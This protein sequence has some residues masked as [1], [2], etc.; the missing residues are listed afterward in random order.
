MTASALPA[1]RAASSDGAPGGPPAGP[2][3]P[4]VITG[5]IAA[6]AAAGT[7]LVLITLLALAGWIAAPHAGVGLPGVLRTAADLWLVGHH[8]GFALHGAGQIGAGRIGM[9]P[10]G[11]VLLP[12]ALLWVAGRWVVRKGEVTRLA[13]VGY[14]ALALAVPYA[15]VAGALALAGQSS[16]AAPSLSQAVLAGFLLALVAGGLG[17]ARALAPWRHLIHLLPPRTRSLFLG[18]LG[19]L[20]VLT[21]AGAILAGASLAASMDGFRA[22]NA[23]LAPGAV[24]AALLLLIQIAYIPNAIVWSICYTLG[25]GFAFGAGTVVAPTGSALGS[26]P[27]LP[28]L[29]ALPSG[30]HSAVP[31]W[32]SV[33]MLSVPYLAGVFGGLLTARAAPTPAI[34]LA[35]LW[36]FAC[37]V[38]TGCAMGL[39]AAFAGGP[40]GSGRLTAVGPS[41]WQA[42][43]VATLEVG[44]AAAVT[45]GLANWLRMR[46]VTASGADLGGADQA[47]AGPAGGEAAYTV[48]DDDS[49][50]R[51][52]LDPWGEGG[53]GDQPPDRSAP[54]DPAALP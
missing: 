7:G 15:L 21:G 54:P 11:L 46:R 1:E 52:Y 25:P 2:A 53:D 48:A 30:A 27:M 39:L 18:T 36:G 42:G 50:H 20:T 44:V 6:C 38:A 14:A 47:D 9:L 19:A 3:R 45:A 8:V 10:L 12:G 28:M 41:G 4:L 22:V 34:E 32:V 35:P 40:L 33:A 43:V 24:G 17:G 16:L 31:G 13:D 49:T 51:I 29:A 26:L 5:A 23:A 37:G